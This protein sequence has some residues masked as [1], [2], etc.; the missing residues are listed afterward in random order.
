MNNI[1]YTN[2]IVNYFPVEQDIPARVISKPVENSSSDIF[3]SYPATQSAPRIWWLPLDLWI[4]RESYPKYFQDAFIGILTDE[5]ARE[6]KAGIGLFKKR[7]DDD[8]A[9]RNQILFG[10]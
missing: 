9:R 1:L 4:T 2:G 3:S 6:M 7:F 10:E 8:L 5:E